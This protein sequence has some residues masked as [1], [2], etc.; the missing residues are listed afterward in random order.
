MKVDAIANEGFKF[1]GWEDGD[2]FP[3]REVILNEDLSLT[4]KFDPITEGTD[5]GN[6]SDNGG[7]QENGGEPGNTGEQENAGEQENTGGQENAGDSA[8][9]GE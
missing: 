4:A 3:S 7:N 1:H 9:S 2:T 6:E 8:S 5:K